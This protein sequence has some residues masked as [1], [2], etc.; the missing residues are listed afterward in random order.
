MKNILLER[1]RPN[2]VRPRKVTGIPVYI[3]DVIV[4]DLDARFGKT[5]IRR[6]FRMPDGHTEEILC[7]TGPE[8]EPCIIF[9]L[10]TDNEVLL[11]RQFRF[12]INSGK[13]KGRLILEFPGGCRKPGQKWR[14]CAKEELMEETGASAKSLEIIGKPIAFNP[15]LECTR[16]TMVLARG[17]TVIN[18]QHLDRSET[19]K[20]VK[21]TLHDF[22]S[23]LVFRTI[24]DGKTV[25]TGY[26]VLDHLGLLG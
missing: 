24:T 14:D 12:A 9:P 17:C 13:R 3:K 25:V 1:P 7:I 2:F 21:M 6:H 20:V 8:R 15:A 5:V 26:A 18:G 22:R 4:D 16:F 23:S 11:V 19:I 10:T